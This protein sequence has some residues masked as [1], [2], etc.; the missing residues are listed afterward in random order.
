MLIAATALARGH[1]LL[2]LNG[3]EFTRL[4]GLQLVVIDGS[5]A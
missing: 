4:P 3:T 5:G 2:T 1:D